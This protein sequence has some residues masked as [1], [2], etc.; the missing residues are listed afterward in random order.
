[1]STNRDLIERFDR[2]SA[3]PDTGSIAQQRRTAEFAKELRD[4]LDEADRAQRAALVAIPQREDDG[5]I[6][7]AF[8]REFIHR[9]ANEGDDVETSL[10]A[11][12]AGWIEDEPDEFWEE[13]AGP[14]LDEIERKFA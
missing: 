14:M 13:Y 11:S 3:R 7:A 8:I 12:A 5:T 2:W 6:H 9:A 10:A 1:M 4:A